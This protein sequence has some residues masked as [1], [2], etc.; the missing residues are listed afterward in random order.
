MKVQRS[1]GKCSDVRSVVSGSEGEGSRVCLT[2]WLV[3]PLFSSMSAML[4]EMATSS[5]SCSKSLREERG[6]EPRHHPEVPSGPTECEQSEPGASGIP[7]STPF[8]GPGQ[9]TGQT[10]RVQASGDGTTQQQPCGSLANR[11]ATALSIQ[12]QCFPDHEDG[13]GQHGLLPFPLR[14]AWKAHVTS[15]PATATWHP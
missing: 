7:H 3:K 11:W 9:D 13:Q 8:R 6:K 10:T 4:A 15:G 12:D 14:P 5:G 2:K 1:G